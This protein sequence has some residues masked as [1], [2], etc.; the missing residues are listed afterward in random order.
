MKDSISKRDWETLSAYLDGQLSNRKQTRLESRLKNDDQLRVALNDLRNTRYKLR[1][2]PR[3]QAPR[4]FMLTPEMAG[5]PI[6]MPRLA[7][8]FGWASAVASFLLVLVLV[9][10]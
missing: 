10:G 2:S 9:A 6:R 8:V 4:N 3:L 7:P 5:H 1:H